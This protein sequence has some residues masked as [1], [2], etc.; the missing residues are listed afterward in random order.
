MGLADLTV[1]TARSAGAFTDFENCGILG[2]SI[3]GHGADDAKSKPGEWR[4]LHSAA[5]K[6]KF[7]V[8]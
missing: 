3:G 2:E 7:E 8:A 5:L 6:W 1:R 4:E